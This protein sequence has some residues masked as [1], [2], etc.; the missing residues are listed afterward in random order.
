MV[1]PDITFITVSLC[2]QGDFPW[3]EK[4]FQY[5]AIFVVGVS[6]ALLYFYLRDNGR[7]ISWKDFVH[8]YVSR[9][10]V[11]SPPDLYII[12]QTSWPPTTGVFCTCI[13]PSVLLSRLIG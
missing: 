10:I 4:D 11:R 6:S 9:G 7:E 2:P 3:D 12:L 13:Y 1:S 8:K 5:M